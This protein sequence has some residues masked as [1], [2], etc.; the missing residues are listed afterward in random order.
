MKLLIKKWFKKIWTWILVW[1]W[2]MFSVWI[3]GSIY[4]YVSLP[5]QDPWNPLSNTIWNNLVDKVNDIWVQLESLS[6]VWKILQVWYAS[7]SDSWSATTSWNNFY[8]VPWLSFTITPSSVNNK[9]ML[10]SSLYAWTSAYQIKYRI[11]RNWVPIILGNWEWGR[12]V[13]TWAVIPYDDN[14]TTMKYQVAF[15]WGTYIDSPNTTS[16]VTYQIQMAAYTWHT[17]YLNRSSAWQNSLSSGYDA[18]PVSSFVGME[19]A[20]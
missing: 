4:A 11:L 6:W 5:N 19:I 20:N 9:I 18:T 13:T 12:P 8:D 2:I 17:V 1:T 10:T 14:G 7:K 3:I 16:A 15:L